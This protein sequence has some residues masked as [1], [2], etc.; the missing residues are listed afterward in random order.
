MSEQKSYIVKA[1]HVLTNV[2]VKIY[3]GLIKVTKTLYTNG[4]LFTNAIFGGK[5]VISI[6]GSTE[7]IEMIRHCDLEK[8]TI[9][10][11]QSDNIVSKSWVE[12]C[13][14]IVSINC[15]LISVRNNLKKPI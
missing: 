1:Y 8:M 7:L 10:T 12:E 15:F 14:D 11:P 2:S 13:L 6:D 4:N 5:I 9:E 3:E